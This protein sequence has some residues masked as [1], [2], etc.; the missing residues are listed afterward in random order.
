L[1]NPT[2]KNILRRDFALSFLGSIGP[3]IAKPT[4]NNI[5]RSTGDYL[6]YKLPNKC[7]RIFKISFYIFGYLLEPCIEIWRFFMKLGRIMAIENLKKQMIFS[8]LHF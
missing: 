7:G 2:H 8:V 3:S 4:H 6:V 1:Q 5:R